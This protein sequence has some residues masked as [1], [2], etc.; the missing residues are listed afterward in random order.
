MQEDIKKVQNISLE[1]PDD[2]FLIFI[3]HSDDAKE[4]ALALVSLQATLENEFRRYIELQSH[5]SPFHSLKLWEWGIDASSRPGGQKGVIDP[6]LYRA[7]ITIFVFKERVGTGTWE[8][9]E[10]AQKRSKD[11]QV[12]ILAFFPDSSPPPKS[13]DFS[14][15]NAIDDWATLM[16][17]KKVLTEDWRGLDSCSVTPC[18]EYKSIDDLK[19]IAQQKLSAAI[20]NI[21]ALKKLPSPQIFDP[22][23]SLIGDIKD[24]SYDRRPMLYHNVDELDGKLVE[25]FLTKPLSLRLLQEENLSSNQNDAERLVLLGC[26]LGSRPTLGAFFCFAP[27]QLIN[28]FASCSLHVVRYKGVGRELSRTE[29]FPMFDNLLNLFERGIYWLVSEA[30]LGRQGQVGSTD[31]DDLEIPEIA[32]REA[33][34][35]ALVHRDYDEHRDQ[36][37]RIEVYDDR[38]EITSYGTLPVSVSIEQLNQYPE[39]LVSV[40][41]NPVI[42]QIFYHMM[43]VELNASGIA[44]MRYLMQKAL[45]PPPKILEQSGSVIVRFDRPIR[46]NSHGGLPVEL[47]RRALVSGSIS[48]NE[49]LKKAVYD[50]CFEK[51]F[52]PVIMEHY[53]K[54]AMDAIALS[55]AMMENADVY[56]G[57][58]TNYY[59]YVPEGEDKSIAEIEYLTAKEKKIHS[60]LFV[61]NITLESDSENHRNG[62]RTQLKLRKKISLDSTV[63]YV[64]SDDE[65]KRKLLESLDR[66]IVPIVLPSAFDAVSG[67]KLY[68]S[69]LRRQLGNITLTGSPAITT[70]TVKLSDTFV[71]LRLSGTSRCETRNFPGNDQSMSKQEDQTSTPEEVL[72]FVFQQHPLLLVIGDPGSGKTTLLKYYALSF[73][74]NKRYQEF[75]FSEPVNVFY[76]P[77]RELRRGETGY[78]SLP[79]SLSAWC[80]KLF[81]DLSDTLFLAWLEESSTLVLL[82][83]LDEISDVT[84]RIAVCGWVDKMVSRFTSARFVVT[85]RST[86]YRKGDGIELEASHLRADI[87]DFSKEQQA[88][89]LQ[90]W[91]KAAFLS[92]IPPGTGDKAEWSTQQ[93]Q[94]AANKADAIINFLAQDKNRSLYLLAGVPLILQ[95]MAMLWKDR[96]YLPGSRLKLYDAALNYMLDYRDRQRGIEPLLAAEDARR[97]LSPISLWMQEE[98]KKD[99]VGRD[100]MQEKMQVLLDTLCNSLPAADFCRNLVDR[101]GLLVEYGEKEYVFR[102][103]SFREYL[104]GVQLEKTIHRGGSLDALV[105]HFGDDWWQEPLRFFIGHVDDAGIFDFFMQKLFDSPVTEYLT[106]KQQ[107]FLMT[108]VEEAPQRKID[109]IQ[110]K[111]LDPATTQNRQR[112]LLECLKIIGKPE[113]LEMVKQFREVH[114]TTKVWR[115]KLGAEYM[116]IKGGSFTFSLTMKQEAVPDLYFAKY[117]VTNKLY[118][119][120][121]NYLVAKDLEFAG[122]LPV[123]RYTD[124]LQAKARKIKGF[125]DYLPEEESLSK[126]FMSYYSNDKRFNKDDQP[127][128]GVKWSAAQAYCL[129]L[130]LLESNGENTDLYRLPTE[131]EWEYAAGGKESRIYPWGNT[132]PST[133]HANYNNNEGTT[134]PVGRYPEGGTPDGLYDIAGN[135]WEWT[136]DWYDNGEVDP[137]VRGGGFHNYNSDALRCSSRF[138]F[139]LSQ[140]FFYVGFRVIR[141][142]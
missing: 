46:I 59:S 5:P 78:A 81:L 68:Q 117:T 88:Q 141:S 26:V 11:T 63:S 27:S 87:M 139:E 52:F 37:T 10:K 3:G 104:A 89:F 1:F 106:P 127:V 96:E 55:K 35:N 13:I 70:F 118:R 71:S 132:E 38:V 23:G 32:L 19:T 124:W 2:A 133:K 121:I 53:P 129:W 120:F 54:H 9:L 62:S 29:M 114:A 20:Y 131:K 22:V 69:T 18:Q 142:S 39:R 116:L 93:E 83:G 51:G 125:S 14:N 105:T 82:D 17:R 108:L 137:A 67:L 21:L 65:L 79:E 8:E 33:L 123:E 36:P 80:E 115:D 77:L 135:V 113:V 34:A 112:Y 74:E 7:Q 100:T 95:I 44:R 58:F 16:K 111:L 31:R 109:A 12:H 40:R 98:L 103:K 122:A 60:L 73:L 110:I 42:A 75:G 91:F 57:I 25:K 15:I 119:R 4:E 56:I 86:G 48:D 45:L 64:Q 134:T 90:R 43:N 140:P 66:I 50:A 28:K 6:A 101:S 76:L 84:E 41:R 107:D 97:V 138:N 47:R 85:S 92:E 99:E 30:H 102:H 24:I 49:P 61:I 128:V 72:S 126:Y 130:S 94:K 136:A